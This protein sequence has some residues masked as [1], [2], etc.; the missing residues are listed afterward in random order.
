MLEYAT[1]K[2]LNLTTPTGRRDVLNDVRA[3]MVGVAESLFALS[4]YATSSEV[5]PAQL[6][7]LGQV[8]A[9]AAD[10]LG[11]VVNDLE[12]GLLSSGASDDEKVMS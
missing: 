5:E 10:A 12:G 9:F 3:D 6:S 2:P 1:E 4:D 8:L 7:M 11:E